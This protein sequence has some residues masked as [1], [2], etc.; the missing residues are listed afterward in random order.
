MT[1][2]NPKVNDYVFWKDHIQGWIYFKCAQYITIE[3]MVK[4]KDEQNVMD[5]NLHKNDRVLILCYK[6][7]WN[8]LKYIKSRRTIYDND[9]V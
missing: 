1:D 6:S 2:Y 3:L 7:Q 4:P 8:E 5:C 9:Q